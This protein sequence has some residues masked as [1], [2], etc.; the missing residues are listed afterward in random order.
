MHTDRGYAMMDWNDIKARGS[1]HYKTGSTEPIDLYKSGGI[2][3]GY[4]IASI[5]KYA[6]RNRSGIPSSRDMEKI[7]HLADMLIAVTM[8]PETEQETG[9]VSSTSTRQKNESEN[10]TKKTTFTEP[11]P[12]YYRGGPNAD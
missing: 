5:I 8:E 7:K 12:A 11:L 10:L 2:L 9:Q 3:Q 4:C 1:D 6:Y